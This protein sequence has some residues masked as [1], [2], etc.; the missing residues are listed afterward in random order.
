MK[1][2]TDDELEALLEIVDHFLELLLHIHRRRQSMP[3]LIK[4]HLSKDIEA[5]IIAYQMISFF[6]SE[7][8]DLELKNLSEIFRDLRSIHNNNTINEKTVNP[9]KME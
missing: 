5:L 2:L 9:P 8:T 3:P 6:Y 1:M 7:N 4:N